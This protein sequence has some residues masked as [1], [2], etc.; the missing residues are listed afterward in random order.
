MN[1][2]YIVIVFDILSLVNL[3]GLF[4]RYFIFLF[5]TH[6]PAFRRTALKVRLSRIIRPR[7]ILLKLVYSKTRTRCAPLKWRSEEEVRIKILFVAANYAANFHRVCFL[8]WL[9]CNA[10]S[11]GRHWGCATS[12]HHIKW[13]IHS[14]RYRN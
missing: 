11:L 13:A 2:N 3:S 7:I 9:L 4:L 6:F 1:K 8:L 10:K 14:Y 5:V 12:L